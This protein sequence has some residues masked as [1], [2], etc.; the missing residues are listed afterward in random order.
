MVPS[1]KLTGGVMIGA[2]SG[3]GGSGSLRGAGCSGAGRGGSGRLRKS[4][5]PGGPVLPGMSSHHN[6]DESTRSA[7]RITLP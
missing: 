1:G 6:G 3:G 5:V 7:P 2:S 4:P